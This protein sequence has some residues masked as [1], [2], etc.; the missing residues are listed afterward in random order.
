MSQSVEL[1]S[2]ELPTDIPQIS[3]SCWQCCGMDTADFTHWFY[4]GEP[5][6]NSQA[7][8][9]AI[10]SETGLNTLNTPSSDYQI[11][12]LLS[13][14]QWQTP[15]LTY[16]FF[17]GDNVYA[18]E[19]G[20]AEVSGAVKQ[21]I[22]Y[23]LHEL[24]APL[25]NLEFE[26]VTETENTYGQLRYHFSEGD[27]DPNFYAYAYLPANT[28][29][30]SAGDVHLNPRYDHDLNTNGFRG[31]PGTHGYTSL[32]HETLHALGLK[33]PGNYNGDGSGDPPF[34][35]P[36]EDTTLNTVMTYNFSG[37]A[38]T[39]MAYDIKALQHLYGAR[40]LNETDTTYRFGTVFGYTDGTKDWG[41]LT[42]ET[43]VSI[44]DSGGMDTLDFSGLKAEDQGYYF[45][46]SENGILTTQAAHNATSFRARGDTSNT[47]YWT[48]DFGTTI[49]FGVTIENVVG[50]S[51]NDEIL[52]NG[53]DNRLEGGAGDDVL[54]GDAGNDF[55]DGGW[56]NDT[57][58]GG[59]GDDRYG[60]DSTGDQVI[61]KANEGIDTVES[62]ISYWLDENVESLI[63]IGDDS[64]NGYGNRLDNLIEG[65]SQ[66][67]YLSGA[68]GDDH[69]R[70]AGG[71]DF[72]LGGEGN[73]VLLGGAGADTLVGDFGNDRLEGGAEIDVLWGGAGADRFIFD[74][75]TQGI[76]IIQDFQWSEGD[77]VEVSAT[78]FGSKA[79][80]SYDV[81]S[82]ALF[83]NGS[84]TVTLDNPVQFATLNNRPQGFIANFDV[85][86]G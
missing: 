6:E 59:T 63:L 46:L 49:A 70:G 52:G 5:F 36:G 53:S 85:I 81:A 64:T 67:N 84:S 68:E 37:G 34:L 11:D 43:K 39:L 44:W 40:E 21:S 3:C 1:I 61:E 22:R 9:S 74:S 55:L 82:G 33:H 12:A 58:E 27:S 2:E 56:G 23:I 73:D 14:Y 31:G 77:K 25:V 29:G 28:I 65:N 19:K 18:K 80:F 45:D 69:L 41:S 66:I 20:V 86:L 24:I 71:D 76:D 4:Q 57:L 10:V 35:P 7:M 72:L 48:T 54:K 79:Q 83:F 32:I 15:K 78:I 47:A 30:P 17:A 51:S 75:W 60:V 42:D 13:G 16:S 26:E 50:T 8:N 38:A 62:S